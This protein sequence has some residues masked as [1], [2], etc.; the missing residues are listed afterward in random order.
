VID[1]AQASRSTLLD[2]LAPVLACP[3]CYGRLDGDLTCTA[4]GAAGQRTG[5]Q[6]RFGGFDDE[7]LR[8][9]SLNRLKETVKQRFGRVYPLAI[10]V[11][12]PVQGVSFIKPF[13]RSFDLD[14]DLVA[15]LGSGTHRRDP[16]LLCVD[17]GAYGNVDIV[18][19]L[20]RLP[21]ADGS[22][23]GAISIAVLEHVPDP[24]VHLAEIRRVLAPGGRLLCYVPFMQPFHASPYDF[25]RYTDVGLRE[26]FHD[27]EV[28]NVRVGAGPTSGMLWVLQEWLA[29]VLSFGSTR[30]YRVLLP[31][32]WVLSPLKL[33]DLLLARHPAAKVIASGFVVE[34]RKPA[35]DGDGART[36]RTS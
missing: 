7:V 21:L 29:I 24:A 35:T 30:L 32:T 13:L 33:L 5:T 12:S 4:C 10:S 23:A 15:D 6:L 18:T 3:S 14:R 8:E 17:G 36:S 27:F 19:D 25:Q 26:Q 20:R 2:R 28:L 31:L 34:A 1:Q 9:D 16:R 11:L 22:L